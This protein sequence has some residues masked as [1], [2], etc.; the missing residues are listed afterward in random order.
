MNLWK[1]IN[2]VFTGV[3]VGCL[4]FSTV[5]AAQ[6]FIT[7]DHEWKEHRNVLL[8]KVHAPHWTITYGYGDDCP[9]EARNNDKALTAAISKALQTW[10]QPLRDYS[11][12]PIVNDF[13]Y[14]RVA[15]PRHGAEARDLW[16]TFYCDLN[17]RSSAHFDEVPGIS[18]YNGTKVVRHFMDTFMHEVG[19]VFGLADTYVPWGELGKPGLSKGGLVG[20]KGTQPDAVMSGHIGVIEGL[21]DD[22]VP[23]DGACPSRRGRHQRYR[24]ALQACA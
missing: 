8:D 2:L 13:R 3:L 10:L 5:P 9:P 7:L 24:L 4:L 12:K 15:D 14:Q 20:T 21:A 23:L 19:H 1:K 6:G 22:L 18:L 11:K 16:I 17:G